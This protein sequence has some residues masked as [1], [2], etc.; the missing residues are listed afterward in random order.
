MRLFICGFSGAGKSTLGREVATRLNKTFID[1]DE[2][3]ADGKRLADQ[4][5]LW[6]WPKFRRLESELVMRVSG[7]L[8]GDSLV[9]SLGGGALNDETVH[10]TKTKGC[11][12]AWLDTPF[13]ECWERINGDQDR[14]LTAKGKDELEKLYGERLHLYQSADITVCGSEAVDELV[15]YMASFS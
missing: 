15:S 2:V 6:G 8:K 4:I 1:T 12:L 10:A 11:K 7:G 14:P 9:V 5:E 13:E 3:L